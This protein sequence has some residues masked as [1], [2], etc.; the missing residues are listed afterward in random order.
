MHDTFATSR[1]DSSHRSF[2]DCEVKM[3]MPRDSCA[4]KGE[5][6]YSEETKCFA[7]GK[8]SFVPAPMKILNVRRCSAAVGCRAKG[9]FCK[10]S[11]R[12]LG[13]AKLKKELRNVVI[14]KHVHTIAIERTRFFLQYT[15]ARDTGSA[16][17][18]LVVGGV[19]IRRCIT[20]N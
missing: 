3:V 10:L 11:T 20:R 5:R 7:S 6:E 4:S 19:F 15:L 2:V 14:M 8:Y 1:N 17:S 13:R 16:S 18:A 9:H 12:N